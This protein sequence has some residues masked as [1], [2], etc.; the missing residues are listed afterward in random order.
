MKPSDKSYINAK[1]SLVMAFVI[2]ILANQMDNSTVKLF[3][4]VI[5]FIE[6]ISAI[7]ELISM[8][9]W[10]KAEEKARE[11][12]VASKI[13][14]LR[15]ELKDCISDINEKIDEAEKEEKAKAKR[16]TT[17][18]KVTNDNNDKKEQD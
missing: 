1:F 7:F 13:K 8:V 4:T 11:E 5:A 9:R 6:V 3:L 12:E 18:K 2:Q 14:E 16:K 17:K 15:N 10:Q